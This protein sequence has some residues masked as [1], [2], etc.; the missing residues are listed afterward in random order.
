MATL[1]PANV[2][3]SGVDTVGA[4]ATATTGDTWANT[5][6]EIALVKNGSGSPIN[7]T[8][9]IQGEVDGQG[10]T[11]PVVSVGAGVT[12]A[13]GPFPPAIYGSTAK[14]T[15][16]SVTSVTIKILKQV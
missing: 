5:G 14:L 9:D 8:L 2:S 1:T 11:D 10:A 13:I 15:C 3:R 7:V 4:A 6:A 16:S 12:K